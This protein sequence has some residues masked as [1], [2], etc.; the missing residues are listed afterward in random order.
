MIR[1]EGPQSAYKALSRNGRLR[2]ANLGASYFTKF[3][4]FGGFGAKPLLPQP[5]I[6]DDNVINALKLVTQVSWEASAA[7]YVRYIDFTCYRL[8]QSQERQPIRLQKVSMRMIIRTCR[9]QLLNIWIN[10]SASMMPEQRVSI[11]D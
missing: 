9:K 10:Q 3:L 2:V 5:L 11:M 6:M 8:E 1:G 4:Y 7:D